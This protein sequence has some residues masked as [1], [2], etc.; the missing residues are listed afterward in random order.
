MFYLQKP[1]FLKA[2]LWE[3]EKKEYRIWIF[4]YGILLSLFLLLN[5]TQWILAIVTYNKELMSQ[6]QFTTPLI[7]SIANFLLVSWTVINYFLTVYKSYKNKSFAFISGFTLF[8]FTIISF[9]NII[10]YLTLLFQDFSKTLENFKSITGIMLFTLTL[11]SLL[12]I[13]PQRKV[14]LIKRMFLIAEN[15]E[16]AQKVA[17][18][19]KNSDFEKMFGNFGAFGPNAT[20]NPNQTASATGENVQNQPEEDLKSKEYREKLQSLST[21]QIRKIA[22]KFQISGYESLSREKLIEILI[23]LNK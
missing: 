18:E 13:Y 6:N 10:S 23:K 16:R 11:I 2:E 21:E 8:I 15:Y 22:Q 7:F 20:R 17:E 19:L 1:E 14:K 4:L 5:F 3:K 9:M 12:T